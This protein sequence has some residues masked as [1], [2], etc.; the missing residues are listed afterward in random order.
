VTRGEPAA[1]R[2][3][4]LARGRVEGTVPLAGE[5]RRVVGTAWVGGRVLAI[6][7]GGGST[8]VYSIDPDERSVVGRVELPGAV[9]LGERSPSGVVLLLATPDAIAPATLAVVD[10]APRV[11]TVRLD[12]IR[13]GTVVSGS[14]T[15][16]LTTMRRPGLALD[17]AGTRA[18]V[19]GAGEPAAA[20]D[21]RTLALRYSRSRFLTAIAKRAEG[22]VR[23]AATLPDGRVVV[24][25]FGLGAS[26]SPFV[27]IV[28][29]RSWSSRTLERDTAWFRVGG[30]MVFTPGDR[31]RGLRMWRPSGTAVVLFSTGSVSA[32]YVLGQRAFV[33]FFGGDLKAAVVDLL[34]G[35]VVR[36][37][38]PAHPLVGAGQP[39]VSN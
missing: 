30:G 16:R 14:G 36:H 2:F 21:L 15:D 32:V 8:T 7:S 1:L 39:I 12:R 28:D 37:T 35:R 34:S 11:R 22:S 20:V 6:V 9:A 19:F 38:L 18:Y 26:A 10:R 5:F 24:S 17:P 4:D 33:T 3:V 23:T 25:G 29:P 13:V 31:G 27:R